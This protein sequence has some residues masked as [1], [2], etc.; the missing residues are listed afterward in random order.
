MCRVD[1]VHVESTCVISPTQVC[2]RAASMPIPPVLL[3]LLLAVGAFAGDLSRNDPFRAF[4][5]QVS[6]QPKFPVCCLKPLS[7]HEPVED[8]VL[9]SFEEWK[10]K[11]WESN[12]LKEQHKAREQVFSQFHGANTNGSGRELMASGNDSRAKRA[13]SIALVQNASSQIGSLS[14]DVFLPQPYQPH[15][16]VP[17]TDRFNYASLDCSARVHMAHRSAK[18]PSAVL[19]SK[20]DKYMLS[21][22]KPA[23]GER[24]FIVLE[25]CEDIRI[26]TVQLANFEFFSGVFKDFSVRVR[27]TYTPEE[28]GWVDAGIYRAKNVRG[29]QSFHPPTS[30][31]DFY[32][33]IRVDFR[34]HY[35]NEYY[36]P[37][38]LLRVYGL[39][40]LEEYK[41]EQWEVESRAKLG[42]SPVADAQVHDQ[43]SV[44]S[45]PIMTQTIESTSETI[46]SSAPIHT[47][48]TSQ[49]HGSEDSQLEHGSLLPSISPGS[50]LAPVR[51]QRLIPDCPDCLVAK[52]TQGEPP[53]HDLRDT[54]SE[55]LQSLFTTSDV[56]LYPITVD[57][58]TPTD[59]TL[60]IS[61][62]YPSTL[63]DESHSTQLSTYSS[64]QPSL[65]S[66]H[67]SSH[68][69][70][71][72][73][74]NIVTPSVPVIS[75]AATPSTSGESI[76]RVIMNRLTALE[77]NHTLYAR[78]VEQ[79]NTAVRELLKRLGE[80]VG[81]LE[82]IGRAQW[83][84]HQRTVQE[85]EKQRQKLQMEIREVLVIVEYLSDEI[86][87]EKR[88]G[89]A[90]LCLLLLVLVFIA[91]TRGSRGEPL[92]IRHDMPTGARLSKNKYWRDWRMRWNLST[93]WTR[94]LKSTS[95]VEGDVSMQGGVSNHSQN[96]SSS[97]PDEFMFPEQKRLLAS[98]DTNLLSLSTDRTH[99]SR[100]RTP[101]LRRNVKRSIPHSLH[102]SP[103]TH[104]KHTHHRTLVRS[105]SAVRRPVLQ[106]SNSHTDALGHR[107][108][109]PGTP[110]SA[111][112]SAKSAHLH[113][114][115][116]TAPTRRDKGDVENVASS[117]VDAFRYPPS[118]RQ[119]TSSDIQVQLESD[120]FIGDRKGIRPKGEEKIPVGPG[121]MPADGGISDGDLSAWEDTDSVPEELF[122]C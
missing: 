38:S 113:E 22:C 9:L 39:T 104:H 35:G 116:R 67:M 59:A 6:R 28:E 58:H 55:L 63:G 31:R 4:S 76:Y 51:P 20:R 108:L 101:S 82:G 5:L 46:P 37:V 11:E 90:Q 115:V 21:P 64:S 98:V 30:L 112:K 36:C 118:Y 73:M 15:F 117:T 99:R 29:V 17:I 91:L 50:F 77:A 18:S 94:P 40:H 43:Q 44:D 87:L 75:Q 16:R 61:T 60:S 52:G 122:D 14:S 33:Y 103:T 23:N 8:Q 3:A 74:V 45:R 42:A 121:V 89:I 12:E 120:L 71:N 107:G 111:R 97:G 41:W 119:R 100:P 93:D 69:T 105:K 19:D 66:S 84:A 48:L 83:Q 79:Q 56:S 102:L 96:N 49:H 7:P 110:R 92:L 78:Y 86:T 32:R 114:V 95:S 65:S 10:A 53:A 88:L 80:D 85:W 13:E 62:V 34:S 106:R 47:S 57:F 2:L 72:G 54:H 24:Q 26:D 1:S 70:S 68:S 25:L 109:W 81:R 27:K